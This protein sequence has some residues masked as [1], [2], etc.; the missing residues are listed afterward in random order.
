MEW[1][2]VSPGDRKK[3]A[4]TETNLK[5]KT[6]RGSELGRENVSHVFSSQCNSFK[7][8]REKEKRRRKIA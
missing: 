7:F 6:Q 3:E 1:I 4:A 8:R 2:I 5:R